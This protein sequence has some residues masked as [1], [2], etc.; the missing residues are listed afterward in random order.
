MSSD[1]N[2][3]AAKIESLRD[4]VSSKENMEIQWSEVVAGRRKTGSYTQR[5]E[6]KPKAVIYNQY[7]L[8]NT[9]TV[10]EFETQIQ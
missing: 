7:E 5:T 4:V 1:I 2:L 8:L 3:L 9:S 10:G 6:S